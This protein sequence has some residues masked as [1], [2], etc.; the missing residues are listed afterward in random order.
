MT[1]V[2]R[3]AQGFGWAFLIVGVLGFFVSRGSM[4]SDPAMAPRLLGLFPVNLFH[5]LVHVASGIAGIVASRT[6]VAAITYCKVFGV[7]YLLLVPLGLL[8]PA[9]GGI[10]PIG[11]HDVWLHALLGAGLAYFG[12]SARQPTTGHARA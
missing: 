2:Q 1:T 11:D 6:T 12:F 9:T 10:M 3:A 4:E 7:L 5:N 8:L